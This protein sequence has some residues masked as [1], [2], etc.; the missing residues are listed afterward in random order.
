LRK[1]AALLAGAAM[2][3]G[4]TAAQAA[5]QIVMELKCGPV[6]I[7]LRPDLGSEARGAGDGTCQER[8]L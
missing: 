2:V 5:N 8:L 7:D 6:V 4:A 3:A 1:F